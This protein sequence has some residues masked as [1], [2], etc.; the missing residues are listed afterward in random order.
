MVIGKTLVLLTL[1]K[2]EWLLTLNFSFVI[3]S[4]ECS[5]AL[6]LPH[7]PQGLGYDLL[8]LSP[9]TQKSY[10]TFFTTLPRKKTKTKCAPFL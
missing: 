1:P 2:L 4:V 5:L 7:L 9:N 3:P 8:W 10:S 6:W